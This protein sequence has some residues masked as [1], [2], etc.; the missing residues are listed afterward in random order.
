VHEL[1]LQTIARCFAFGHETPGQRQI[2]V[3][4]KAV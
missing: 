1:V 4:L 3:H 2:L